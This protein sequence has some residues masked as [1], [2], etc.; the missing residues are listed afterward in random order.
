MKYLK[1]VKGFFARPHKSRVLRYKE[2]IASASLGGGFGAWIG[3][4]IGIAMLGTAFVGTILF[5]TICAVIGVLL[6][7]DLRRLF[8]RKDKGENTDATDN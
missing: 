2:R 5:T 1:I 6:V 3:S 8:R 7:P 4:S